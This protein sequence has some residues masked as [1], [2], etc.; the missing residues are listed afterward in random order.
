MA[1][2]TRV[3][4]DARPLEGKLSGIGYYTLYLLQ[5]LVTSEQY[6]WFL[7]TNYPIT[8]F[9]FLDNSNV[10]VVSFEMAFPKAGTILSQT[11]F[12]YWCRKNSIDLFWSPRH[13]LPL[14]LPFSVVQ[15]CNHT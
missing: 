2:R 12:P 10:H 3:A 13:H 6:D 7:L 8:E 9:E 1:K 4:V 14:L 11:T 15:V 5:E